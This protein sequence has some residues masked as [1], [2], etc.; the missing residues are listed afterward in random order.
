LGLI[1][2][3]VAFMAPV[4]SAAVVYDSSGFES[5]KFITGALAN[6]DVA[7][8]PWLK[9]GG[10]GTATVTTSNAFTGTQA[11][12]VT[13]PAAVTGDTRWAV[14]KPSIPVSTGFDIFDTD[15]DIRVEQA[16]FGPD[17]G[18]AFGLEAYD[19]V[20]TP[21]LPKLIG[22]LTIDATTGDVLYLTTKQGNPNGGV[23]TETGVAIS[24][25]AYHHLKLRV[26]FPNGNYQVYVDNALLKTEK[27][28]DSGVKVFSDAPIATF[29]ASAT[30]IANGTGSAY[31][32]NYVIA[33]IPEPTGVALIG[34]A[35]AGFAGR[36]R[37]QTVVA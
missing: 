22:S 18:P 25:G 37:R 33:S 1:A 34:L 4:A 21:L 12:L 17:F 28:V 14:I 32:D 27:F 10:T 30:S 13:R 24:R 35:L 26:D 20:T 15:V 9:D 31:F 11:V 23:L 29:A 7:G 16:N 8:G 19:A 5:P 2:A 36:R 3:A 6:Q